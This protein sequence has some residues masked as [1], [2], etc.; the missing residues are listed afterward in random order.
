MLAVHAENGPQ[1]IGGEAIGGA[2]TMADRTG[3]HDVPEA[4]WQAFEEFMRQTGFADPRL[5]H[6]RHHL[7]PPQSRQTERLFQMAQFRLT[8]DQPCHLPG[9]GAHFP[10][11]A[12]MRRDQPEQLH[13]LGNARDAMRAEH[14]QIDRAMRQQSGAFGKADGIRGGELF[15]TMRDMGDNAHRVVIRRVVAHGT[16]HHLAR[17]QPHPHIDATMQRGDIGQDR[18]C[19]KAGAGGVVFGGHRRAEQRHDAVALHPVD[20]AA[21]VLHGLDHFLHRR[22]EQ[23]HGLFRV[24]R[25]DHR[26]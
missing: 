6:H 16:D 18:L 7:R 21:I 22:V 15:Q 3:A 20:R 13:L 10:R 11:W 14:F 1:D 24:Q 25:L 26:G 23:Q 17:I 2:G 19:G 12:F 4:L 5:T 8:A 9:R